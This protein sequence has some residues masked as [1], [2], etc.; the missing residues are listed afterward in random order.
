VI[1][2]GSNVTSRSAAPNYQM[3]H[4]PA[5]TP[6]AADPDVTKGGNWYFRII[7][8]DDLQGKILAYY[9]RSVLG[10]QSV[11]VITDT[12]PYSR[13]LGNVFSQTAA[14]I[15]L[16]VSREFTVPDDPDDPLMLDIAR[17]ISLMNRLESVVLLME[18]ER[19]RHL[20]PLL[21][22]MGSKADLIGS[23]VLSQIAFA[24]SDE[25]GPRAPDYMEGMLV[26]V[27]FLGAA[28][29]ARA[30]RFLDGYEQRYKTPAPWPAVF[31]YDGAL[32]VIEA[33]RRVGAPF[34]PDS[35][36]AARQ[37]IRD[38][39]AA[40]NASELGLSGLTGLIYF[41]DGDAQRPV[42]LARVQ[43][44]QLVPAP[45]QLDLVENAKMVDVLREE[46]E[47]TIDFEGSFLR[48][49]TVVKSGIRINSISKVDYAAKKFTADFDL[50]F[51]YRGKFD[52]GELVFSNAIT[53][54][55]LNKP[56]ISR[57]VAGE[58]YEL[59][60]VK[61]D[62]GY[63]VKAAD[64]RTGALDFNLEY[65]HP[66]RD[67]SRLVFLPDIAAMG[68]TSPHWNWADA[69]RA[70]PVIDPVSGWVVNAASVSQEIFSRSTFGDPLMPTVELPFSAFRAT[71]GVRKGEV[72]I[73]H[74][75][76]A[77]LPQ[78]KSWMVLGLL[79]VL[80]LVM[81]AP[82]MRSKAPLATTLMRLILATLIFY[83]V[84]G[85]TF[86]WTQKRLE[87]YQ[88]QILSNLF[89]SLWWLIPAC[90][91]IVLLPIVLWGPIE[92]RTGYPLSAIARTGVNVAV[93]LV[94][95]TCIMAF[96]FEQP[97]TSIW[98]A[99]GVLTLVL[100]IALQSLILD[101]FAGLMLSAERPFSIGDWVALSGPRVQSPDG[102]VEEMN[103]R[104]TR[105]WTRDNNALVVPNSAIAQATVTNYSAT[106]RAS[107][108]NIPIV[109]ESDVPV[110]QALGL[111]VEGAQAAIASG[112]ILP[113][114]APKAVVDKIESFGISYKV[115]VYH[116]MSAASRDAA[117]TVV[118][119]SVMRHLAKHAIRTAWPKQFSVVSGEPWSSD[120]KPQ[121]AARPVG[122]VTESSQAAAE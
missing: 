120:A 5:V 41:K 115:Q 65:Y 9:I 60:N 37:A 76:D 33:I 64:I 47:D 43:Q 59:F 99:S 57:T 88:V 94:A 20:L 39:L 71:V 45:Q 97:L 113:E 118:V 13:K 40:M 49:T 105:L 112:H 15:A 78:I 67:L 89:E 75:L 87:I 54:I 79:A 90:W 63:S 10:Y 72:S 98:A 2:H 83:V 61:G 3:H 27:P 21:R 116:D 11:A 32:A 109:L 84:E 68:A 42:Y 100:G 17:Q 55:T 86:E 58:K 66:R 73:R 22:A 28:A 107:R 106:S 104:T 110:P 69:L 36:L 23:D 95:G 46:G 70:R 35:Q 111:L 18:P 92:R 82:G 101:A 16:N 114:P 25:N 51:R 81:L 44:G 122:A 52:P 1:G 14:H 103:W 102:R 8:N 117:T 30:R 77:I 121:P 7:F 12:T 53:P 74:Y 29:S 108:V 34:N 38:Q 85:L 80:F 119:D 31:G 24:S 26:S 62:F 19:A 6:T 50:W 4:V 93:L 96:V 48:I 56:Q 91:A